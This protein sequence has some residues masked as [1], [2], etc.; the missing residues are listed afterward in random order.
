MSFPFKD[1]YTAKRR[2]LK[3]TARLFRSGWSCVSDIALATPYRLYGMVEQRMRDGELRDIT[4]NTILDIQPLACYSGELAGGLRGV[5]WF[6]GAYARDGVNVGCGDVM[7]CYYRDMPALMAEHLEVDAFCAVVPPMDQSGCFSLFDGSN[8]EVLARKARHIFLEVNPNM[9]RIPSAPFVHISQ[10]TALYESEAPLPVLPPRPPDEVSTTIGSLIAEE[11][12]H[13]ATL[14]L[15]IGAIPEAVGRAL[16]DKRHL[17]IHT[18]MFT[19]S[20]VDLITCGA[21]DNSLKPIHTG[22][23]VATFAFGSRYMYDFLND[24]PAVELLPV[25]YTNDPKI[26]AR[27][28]HMISVN[29][30]LEVDFFGQVCAESIGSRHFSGT[31]G[32]VDFVRGAVESPGGKSFIAFPSTARSGTVSKIKPALTP[33]AV[34]TTGKNDVGYIVTEYGVARLRGKTLSQHTRA[35]LDIAHPGT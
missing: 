29:A 7:P 9:P 8:G 20:M 30:A 1:T 32:Q 21:V 23:S 18:E 26:I 28:P 12:P 11:I 33:G 25:S 22:R 34:V 14:Q 15:G 31:G 19:D 13:G 17:G 3:D 2:S 10:V 5:S 35:L 27:H 16:K 24:N 6:S 4:M